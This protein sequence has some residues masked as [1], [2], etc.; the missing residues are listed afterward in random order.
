MPGSLPARAAALAALACAA[1]A[2]TPTEGT[3]SPLSEPSE[4]AGPPAEAQ[5]P[6]RP[7][8]LPLDTVDPCTL[9]S[10]SA[11]RGLSIDRDP[12]AGT[13]DGMRT[14]TLHQQSEQPMYDVLVT[15][16]PDADVE[17]WI[18]GRTARPGAAA[19]QQ[20]VIDGFPAVRMTP[21]EQAPGECDVAVGVAES[22]SLHVRVSAYPST[23]SSE[24]RSEEPD[25]ELPQACEIAEQAA[26]AAVAALR[27]KG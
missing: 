2:C 14:C 12:R 27:E 13:A 3:G 16:Y 25:A 26:A 11:L 9:F 1:V 18:S 22:Q 21:S 23:Q 24:E 8:E 15:A 17:T 4:G 20:R 5:L 6:G 10:K 19:V 7:A